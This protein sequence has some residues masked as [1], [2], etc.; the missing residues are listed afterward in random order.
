MMKVLEAVHH[1]IARRITGK[2]ARPD[3][4]GRKVRN[5]PKQKRL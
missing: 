4:S 2:T 1:K 5:D 3:A